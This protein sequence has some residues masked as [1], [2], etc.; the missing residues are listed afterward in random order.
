[1]K[2]AI[3]ILGLALLIL[4]LN[5]VSAKEA[6]SA[7]LEKNRAGEAQET[8]TPQ[9]NHWQEEA[10]KS[11]RQMCEFIQMD[12][13]QCAEARKIF[14]SRL[15]EMDEI[16][17]SARQGGMTQAEAR[18]RLAESFKKHRELF[19]ALLSQAQR[20]RLVQW[21][22]PRGQEKRKGSRS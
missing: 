2:T 13:Q 15:R 20:E 7:N 10:E 14:D 16:L 18:A 1:M 19:E 22:N 8:A 3:L 6:G 11:F 5:T 4:P 9:K 21:E 17:V 12:E